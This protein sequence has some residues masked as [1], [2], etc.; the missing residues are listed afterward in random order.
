[1]GSAAAIVRCGRKADRAAAPC[2]DVQ[3]LRQLAGGSGNEDHVD[4]ATSLQPL[5]PA[6]VFCQWCFI[7]ALVLFECSEQHVKEWCNHQRYEVTTRG[8][9]GRIYLVMFLSNWNRRLT[10]LI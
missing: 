4:S 10:G 5:T 6:T 7:T 9:L 3:S 8:C 2:L 1:M